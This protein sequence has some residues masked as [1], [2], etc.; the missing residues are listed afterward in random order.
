[1]PGMKVSEVGEFGLIQRLSRMISDAG[2]GASHEGAKFPLVLGIG[3]DTAAWQAREVVEL[4]TT[5]TVVEGVH[6]TRATTPW[7]DLGWKVMAANLSDIAAMGGLPT[8]ALV[9]L[10]LPGDTKVA[11]IDRLYEGMVWACREYRTVIAGGDV[12]RSPVCFVSVALNGYTEGPPL[13]RS[14]AR[15]GDLLAVTGPLGGSRGGLEVMLGD[16]TDVTPG[17][18]EYLQRAHRHPEPRLEVGRILAGE[19]V[20]AAMDISDGLAD[21]VGK[22]MASSGLAAR[23]DLPQLPVHPLLVEAFGERAPRMALAGG[24]D[25][26]LV[27]AAPLPVMERTLARIPGGAV[28]GRVVAGLAGEVTVVDASGR[29]VPVHEAGWDH[30]RSWRSL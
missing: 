25:Y 17:A 23:L 24:E 15:D 30:F 4:G 11:D 2:V 29:P 16:G 14:A 27:Y 19:G 7:K 26:E 10:G 6:F 21:D 12:V 8:Y 28:V 18:R 5:D 20:V 1:M 9:T 13:T 22:F 3:D